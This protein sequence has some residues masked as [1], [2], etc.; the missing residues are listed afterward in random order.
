MTK[1]SKLRFAVREQK[2]KEG[3]WGGMQTSDLLSTPFVCLSV[4]DCF[5][6]LYTYVAYKV[7]WLIFRVCDVLSSVPA[8]TGACPSRAY[9][10]ASSCYI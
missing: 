9:S 10:T 2:M 8:T 3:V 5:E 1:Q 4:L 6:L 7:Y